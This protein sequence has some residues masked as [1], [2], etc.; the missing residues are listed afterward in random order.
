MDAFEQL[1]SHGYEKLKA[2]I[3]F[4]SVP[5]AS[6]HQDL[7]KFLYDQVI[8]CSMMPQKV[9]EQSMHI[10]QLTLAYRYILTQR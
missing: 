1:K 9:G 8:S 4:A 2:D 3:T 5:P 6:A 7:L 10:T